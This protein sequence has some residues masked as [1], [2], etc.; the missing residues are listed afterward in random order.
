MSILVLLLRLGKGEA[1]VVCLAIGD[2]LKRLTWVS[3]IHASKTLIVLRIIQ[4]VYMIVPHNNC[5]FTDNYDIDMY[6]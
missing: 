6:S 4:I 3:A 1:D 5:R 2:V